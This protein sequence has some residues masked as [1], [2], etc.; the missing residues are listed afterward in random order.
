MAL[1]TDW[2]TDKVNDRVAQIL[3]E[4]K[5]YKE[6]SFIHTNLDIVL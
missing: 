4:V 2:R 3:N 1:G 6:Q 5:D